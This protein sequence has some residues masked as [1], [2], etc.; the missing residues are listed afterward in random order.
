MVNVPFMISG[1]GSVGVGGWGGS[2]SESG[3]AVGSGDG[4]AVGEGSGDAGVPPPPQPAKTT[5]L[6]NRHKAM[7]KNLFILQLSS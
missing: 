1:I 2:G 6:S 4:D 5:M 3:D 7:A